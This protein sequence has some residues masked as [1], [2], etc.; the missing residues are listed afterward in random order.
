MLVAVNKETWN[1]NLKGTWEHESQRIKFLK[2]ADVRYQ[3]RWPAWKNKQ[4]NQLIKLVSRE[5]KTLQPDLGGNICAW[6]CRD[7]KDGQLVLISVH[8]GYASKFY[9]FETEI[10]RLSGYAI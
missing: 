9:A 2:D 3:I 10:Y 6:R 5:K 1:V 4:S 8:V 7:V